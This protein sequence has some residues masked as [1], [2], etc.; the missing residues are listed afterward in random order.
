MMSQAQVFKSIFPLG[1]SPS[2]LSPPHS[3]MQFRE[4]ICLVSLISHCLP[5]IHHFYWSFTTTVTRVSPETP[6]D[7]WKAMSWREVC[8][9]LWWCWRQGL[10]LLGEGD[11]G[12]VGRVTQVR[13]EQVSSHAF[14][15]Q[16]VHSSPP[17]RHPPLMWVWSPSV[18]DALCSLDHSGCLQVLASSHFQSTALWFL[19]FCSVCNK[20]LQVSQA[21][22]YTTYLDYRRPGER[23][24]ITFCLFHTG[25]PEF[26][27]FPQNHKNVCKSMK[28]CFTHF[29]Q[30]FVCWFT[31]CIMYFGG[32]W[33]AKGNKIDIV[34]GS[35]SPHS[36]E[37]KIE[38]EVID[39]LSWGTHWS[40]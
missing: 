33:D 1:M 28:A 27:K 36:T 15:R 2:P 9:D 25:W 30:P 37:G 23:R 20:S 10:I 17:P 29:L 13:I 32:G 24:T 19:A 14:L 21:F 3:G 7:F 22:Q 18:K 35:R 16:W 11:G 34:L 8:N 12:P 38:D 26:Q 39:M 31:K 40:K 5:T 6:L 4:G